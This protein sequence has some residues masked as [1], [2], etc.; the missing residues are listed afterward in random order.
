[1]IEDPVVRPTPLQWVRYAYIGTLPPKNHAWVLYDA[2]CSTWILRHLVRYLC[3]VTPLIVAVIVFLPAT[4]SIR[5]EASIAA[6]GSLLLG[7][8]CFTTESLERRVEKAGYPNGLAG[9]M[10]EERAT[11]A[12]RAVAARAR[13]RREGRRLN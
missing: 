11:A 7:Y 5:V 6:G 9:R 3:L 13:A 10:R 8:M 1:V 2:T 4:M 12:Q